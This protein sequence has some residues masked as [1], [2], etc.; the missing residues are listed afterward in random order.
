MGCLSLTKRA[1]CANRS[2][3]PAYLISYDL[4]SNKKGDQP[5]EGT[6]EYD[7]IHKAIEALDP[8][9]IRPLYSV[10]LIQ[11]NGT[12][13]DVRSELD[14][15]T[16]PQDSILVLRIDSASQD[17]RAATKNLGPRTQDW[18]TQHVG[19]IHYSM[20]VQIVAIR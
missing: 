5:R 15:A 7:D 12:A 9:C 16:D 3:M 11:H 2:S 13:L 19:T 6:R 4:R 14:K 10:W 17:L 8:N 18:L 20:P 1:F